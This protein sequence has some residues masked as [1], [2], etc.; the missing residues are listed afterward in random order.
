MPYVINKSDGSVLLTLIDGTL[1]NSLDVTLVGKNYTGFGEFINENFVKILENFSGVSAP[2]KPI[3]GQLWYDKSEGRLKIYSLTGW[4]GANGTVV[5]DAQPVTL[6]TGDIWID[7]KQK[8]M[9]FWD[10]TGIYEAAK[11]WG[12]SQGKTGLIA[13]TINDIDANSKNILSLYVNGVKIGIFSNDK[14]TPNDKIDGWSGDDWDVSKSNY[15]FGQRVRYAVDNKPLA[16]EMIRAF[17]SAGIKPVG[18]ALSSTYWKQVYI[19]PGFN[20]LGVL[21]GY[22]D[23]TTVLRAQNL[24]DNENN[25]FAATDFLKRT[26]DDVTTGKITIQNDSGLSLGLH[27]NANLKLDGYDF[28]IENTAQDGNISIKTTNSTSEYTALYFD[29]TNNR[30]GIFN[31]TPQATLDVTG[32]AIISGTVAVGGVLQVATLS[33]EPSSPAN[34][35]IYYDTVTNKFKGYA[36]GTW[37]DL[38]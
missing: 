18:D 36:D 7:S 31:T 10:G 20:T 33:T 8:K 2:T 6:T 30:I 11:Q 12:D 38:N 27:Q 26:S 15:A 17:V 34:G 9:Y 16:F 3:E 24:I 29:A 14:F 1:N 37:V 13:E 19:N 32:D 22:V 21:S 25:V 28:V 23:D 5:A 4:K 35:M